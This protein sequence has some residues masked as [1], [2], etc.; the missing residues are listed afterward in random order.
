MRKS[1][2][3]ALTAVVLVALGATSALAASQLMASGGGKT[4][5]GASF[6]FNAK[7]N[8]KGSFNYVGVTE[9]GITV[10][11]KAIPVGSKFHGHCKNYTRVNFISNVEVRLFA[12]CRG[13]FFVD[14]GPPIRGKVFIQAHV[15]DNGE[16]GKKDRAC[17]AWGLNP[18]PGQSKP[19]LFV[20]DCGKTDH[21]NI[22]VKTV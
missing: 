13:M 4:H 9:F 21:G 11:G 2:V 8:E 16:P 19:G 17:I 12:G 1:V 22:Q 10:G 5:D 20:F 14:G 3:A 15:I 18:S 6:G 7:D